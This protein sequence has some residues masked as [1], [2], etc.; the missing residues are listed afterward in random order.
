MNLHQLHIFYVIADPMRPT[1]TLDNLFSAL[2]G[3][4]LLEVRHM[5]GLPLSLVGA[6]Y[7]LDLPTEEEVAQSMLTNF[8]EK[9]YALTEQGLPD[10]FVTYAVVLGI[11]NILRTWGDEVCGEINADN[12]KRAIPFFQAR[13]AEGKLS[14]KELEHMVGMTEEAINNRRG[15]VELNRERYNQFCDVVVKTLV[16]DVP[17]PE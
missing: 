1:N 17:M 13:A 8:K 15:N 12:L 14:K 5:I 9:C 2:E 3:L 4:D 11:L 10:F 16:G 7:D 6:T